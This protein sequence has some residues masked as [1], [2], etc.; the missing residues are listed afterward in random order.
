MQ[1]SRAEQEQAVERFL[2]AL[3]GGDVQHLL[4]V[5]APDVVLVSDGGG[6]VAAAL[7]PIEGAELVA[8]FLARFATVAPGAQ[9]GTAVLNGAPALLIDLQGATDTAVSLVVQDGRIARIYA[10][11]NPQKLARLDSETLLTR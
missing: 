4:E 6:V 1:V 2:E 10:V 8:R 7:R 11:R 5:L 9:A 3:Q